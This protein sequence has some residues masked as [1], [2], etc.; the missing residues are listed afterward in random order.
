MINRKSSYA[1][2]SLV[3]SYFDTSW[4]SISWKKG[5]SFSRLDNAILQNTISTSSINGSYKYFIDV[6]AVNYNILRI[7]NGM[8]GL[9]YSN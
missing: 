3:R 4:P 9:A 1:L 6:Y 7:T 8:G 5:W 2:R